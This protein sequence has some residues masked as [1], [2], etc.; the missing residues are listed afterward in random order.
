MKKKFIVFIL[1]FLVAGVMNV[2]AACNNKEL[3][4]WSNSVY[5]VQTDYVDKGLIV[6][7]EGLYKRMDYLGYAYLLSLSTPRDDVVMKDIDN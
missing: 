4:K 3:I 5:I 7:E 2:N 1:L 6:D